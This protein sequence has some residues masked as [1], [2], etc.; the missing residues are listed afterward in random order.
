[1]LLEA[2]SINHVILHFQSLYN[3]N[4]Q[5]EIRGVRV[6][7]IS[8]SKLQIIRTLVRSVFSLAHDIISGKIFN[9]KIQFLFCSSKLTMIE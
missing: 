8:K 6:Q 4:S 3:E 1:M 5:Y 2:S 9:Y 7:I